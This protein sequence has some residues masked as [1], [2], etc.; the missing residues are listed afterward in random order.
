MILDIINSDNDENN[1]MHYM[2]FV[3]AYNASYYPTIRISSVKNVYTCLFQ[4]A[5]T[6]NQENATHID[7]LILNIRALKLQTIL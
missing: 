2:L 5:N 7:E 1:K 3:N 6:Q 4:I